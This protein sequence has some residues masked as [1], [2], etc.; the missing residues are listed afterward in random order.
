MC[1]LTIL[2]KDPLT[3]ILIRK[4]NGIIYNTTFI[5]GYCSERKWITRILRYMRDRSAGN[6]NEENELILTL[7]QILSLFYITPSE[8]KLIFKEIQSPWAKVKHS[9]FSF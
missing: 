2:S 5:K 8:L 7:I 3:I 9:F 4:L 6:T 1:L